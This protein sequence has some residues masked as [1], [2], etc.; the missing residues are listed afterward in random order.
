MLKMK[1]LPEKH[2]R[3]AEIAIREERMEENDKKDVLFVQKTRSQEIDTTLVPETRVPDVCLSIL[4]VACV[5]T[6]AS[7][8]SRDQFLPK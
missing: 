2:P 3:K 1:Y 6:S 5:V 4:A 8:G 7:A